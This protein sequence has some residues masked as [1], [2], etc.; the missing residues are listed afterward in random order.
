MKSLFRSAPLDRHGSNFKP[1]RIAMADKTEKIK[2]KIDD[3]ADKAKELTEKAS[4]AAKNAAQKVGQ[5][6]KDTGEAIQ[7]QGK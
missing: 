2:E 4:G 7:K 3:A 6:V 5:K 1:R